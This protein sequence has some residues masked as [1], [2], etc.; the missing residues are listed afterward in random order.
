MGLLN[1]GKANFLLYPRWRIFN[2][3]R[4]QH[5]VDKTRLL[6]AAKNYTRDVKASAEIRYR[7]KINK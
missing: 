1:G 6:G 7:E 4:Y 3:T 2:G 5:A